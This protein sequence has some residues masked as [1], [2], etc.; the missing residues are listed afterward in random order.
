MTGTRCEDFIVGEQQSSR[1]ASIVIP[2]LLLLI[3]LTVVAFV[4]YKW[5]IKGAKGFQHQRMTNGAM[6]V[7]IGN[8]TYKMYEGE[9]DD[10]VGELLDADF[11]LDPDKV[12][13]CGLCRVLPEVGGAGGNLLRL[14]GLAV[15]RSW[16][17]SEGLN[18][19]CC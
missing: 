9:P 11:A 5:R 19:L 16:G 4:W 13:G 10:D 15:Q 7:E 17:G 12:R 1:T 3:L 14:S 18:R 6:N 8:P 2:I